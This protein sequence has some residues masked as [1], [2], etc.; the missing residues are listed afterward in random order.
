RR[1]SALRRTSQLVRRNSGVHSERGAPRN[2][3]PDCFLSTYNSKANPMTVSL[4]RVYDK[5]GRTDGTRI[6]VDR[7]WP[8]GLTKERAAVDQWL[9]DVAPSNEL[10]KWF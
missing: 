8:R 9:R 5:P 10:R 4:K 1:V 6:L 7:L 2:F 3:E